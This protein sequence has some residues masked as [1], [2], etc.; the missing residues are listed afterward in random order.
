MVAVPLIEI[1]PVAD[2]G[3]I[4]RAIG[5]LDGYDVIVVTSANA[6]D[7]FAGALVSHGAWPVASTAIVA[8]G[9]AT[10]ARLREHG[11][12]VE[13]TGSRATGAALAADL[14]HL[15]VRG[16]RILLPRSRRGRP[17]LAD[18]L[19]SAGAVVD[20]VAFY[21]TVPVRPDG[22]DAARLTEVDAVVLT[23]PSAV[24]SL[25]DVLGP[26]DACRVR[27][28]TIGPTTSA[29]AREAGLAVTAEAREQSPDGIVAA[30][31]GVRWDQPAAS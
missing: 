25:V 19:R 17:E 21:D 9:P 4:R 7:R 10:A 28:V 24:A 11:L 15:G 29:A 22:E 6:A 30:L 12:R 13:I 14:A 5:A 8:I 16:R 18:G 31:L 3:E 26:A 23:S 27:A 2:G 20:D 1:V